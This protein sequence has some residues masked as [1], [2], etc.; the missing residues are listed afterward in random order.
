MNVKITEK[1]IIFKVTEDE[2]KILVTGQAL[3][4]ATPIG[5][6][7]FAMVIDPDPV[8]YFEGS[9]PDPLQLILDRDEA[10]LIYCTSKDQIQK[11]VDMGKRKEGLMIHTDNG[12]KVF[13]QVDVRADSR[14]RKKD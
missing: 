9:T 12:L 3:E 5:G 7:S 11:L 6:R 1:S 13:L 10:C 2:L 4:R 8:P 14:P